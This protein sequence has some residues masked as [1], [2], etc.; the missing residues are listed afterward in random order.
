MI[1]SKVE[2]KIKNVA[3][4]KTFEMVFRFCLKSLKELMECKQVLVPT[5]RD[6]IEEAFKAGYIEDEQ[7]W[8][9]LMYF[10]NELMHVYDEDQAK[11]A[12]A[13]IQT[14][15]VPCML[16][17]VTKLKKHIDEVGVVV[18]KSE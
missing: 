8:I 3:I 10:G 1:Q 16:V 13:V 2:E 4:I 9:D 7:D 12:L 6:A 14:K 11:E 5:P 18:Y 17:L 15:A